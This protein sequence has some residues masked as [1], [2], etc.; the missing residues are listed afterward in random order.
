MHRISGR[1][2]CQGAPRIR[3]RM[4]RDSSLYFQILS[5]RYEVNNSLLA[6]Q[7]TP[8]QNNTWLGKRFAKHWHYDEYSDGRLLENLFYPHVRKTTSLQGVDIR[9]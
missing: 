3:I 2:P 7:V 4:Q 6:M 1:L 8:A 5:L 9:T